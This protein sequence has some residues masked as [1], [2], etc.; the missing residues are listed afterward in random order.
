LEAD[1]L[2]LIFNGVIIVLFTA[3]L[4]LSKKYILGRD[5][6]TE[7]STKIE[8]IEEELGIYFNKDTSTISSSDES[9]LDSVKREFQRD[10]IQKSA[11][12]TQSA[13][14]SFSNISIEQQ[15]IESGGKMFSQY[16]IDF[17]SAL[18]RNETEF[19]QDMT[20]LLDAV[21]NLES[22]DQQNYIS[23]AE[24]ESGIDIGKSMFYDRI[25][26]RL[27]RL[28]RKE[29]Y[30]SEPFL[31]FGKIA[32]LGLKNL[33]NISYKD[34]FESLN[35][36]KEAGY[37]QDYI[38]INPQL[39]I[40]TQLKEKVKFT[41]SEKVVLALAYDDDLTIEKLVENSKWKKIYAEKVVNGLINKGIAVLSDNNIEIIG[42][43]TT[44]E[45]QERMILEENLLK[46]L[47]EKEKLR[48][49]QQKTLEKQFKIQPVES[50]KPV[51]PNIIEEE[52]EKEED[53]ET[54]KVIT[55]SAELKKLKIPTVKSLKPNTA[56][57]KNLRLVKQS[58]K[59]IPQPAKE[60]S[61]VEGEITGIDDDLK[62]KITEHKE[63][64]E[65]IKKSTENGSNIPGKEL[66]DDEK[67]IIFD[68]DFED[69]I[70]S[71]YIGDDLDDEDISEEAIVD[72]VMSVFEQYEHINGGLMDIRSIHYHI[73]E[74]YPDLT[75]D[76]LVKSIKK[77]K[78][79]GLVTKEIKLK[80][81]TILLFKDIKLDKDMLKV[82]ETININGWM[83]KDEL[84]EFLKWD[85][86]KTLNTMKK[87]QDIEVLRLG[88]ENKV[89]IP[90]LNA[91]K[92]N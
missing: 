38:E 17:R 68:E 73:K 5:G 4:F 13:Q 12:M 33:K 39:T 22:F 64:E 6:K 16:S 74:L 10:I 89:I 63:I 86:E 1:L 62:K 76:D 50:V 84:S 41:N 52:I 58:V 8:V 92:N 65:N 48:E 55:K 31:S 70:G 29:K 77:L 71:E 72:A 44:Q 36:M 56:S 46:G 54:K 19:K 81:N 18:P 15:S 60:V 28:M 35:F 32:Y 9:E 42:F 79:M 43:E 69:L 78:E 80:N 61:L 25:T 7:S 82:L 83:T 85:E 87:L 3:I 34:M 11:K 23:E 75:L 51:K 90:G 57:G 14:K 27:Y 30:N 49:K 53:F 40:I 26:S 47:E 21:K 20:D 37:I 24:I 66:S 88:S 91:E 45:K 2:I 59:T 67:F